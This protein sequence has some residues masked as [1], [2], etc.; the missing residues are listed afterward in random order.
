MKLINPVGRTTKMDTQAY[1][2]VSPMQ[3][4]ICSG[5][6]AVAVDIAKSSAGTGCACY[7]AGDSKNQM[8]NYTA[9]YIN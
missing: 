8:A 3:G 6:T 4:C 5:S 9:A 1:Y 2:G 7:C